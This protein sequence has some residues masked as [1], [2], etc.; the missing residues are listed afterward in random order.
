MIVTA[1]P[2]DLDALQ[3][4]QRVPGDAG[5]DHQCSASRLE[6]LGLRPRRRRRILETLTSEQ[7]LM[8]AANGAYRR[9]MRRCVPRAKSGSAGSARLAPVS[10]PL[11]RA[12]GDD[13]RVPPRNTSSRSRAAAASQARML[14]RS[15][16][17]RHIERLEPRGQ[18]LAVHAKPFEQASV[19]AAS[20]RPPRSSGSY[21]SA[22][23]STAAPDAKSSRRRMS[24]SWRSSRCPTCCCVPTTLFRLAAAALRIRNGVQERG[25]ARGCPRSR[26]SIA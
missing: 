26:S 1:D 4:T 16:R 3:C 12:R 24:R 2:I 21:G 6:S 15:R 17:R 23:V 14:R 9:A 20:D 8:H 19:A 11:A 18:R 10:T 25:G 5:A 7:F 22:A 13:R